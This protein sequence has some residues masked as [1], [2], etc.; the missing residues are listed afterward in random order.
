MLEAVA[1][2]H[3]VDDQLW[4]EAGILGRRCPGQSADVQVE[5]VK[6]VANFLP[7]DERQRLIRGGVSEIEAPTQL[8]VRLDREKAKGAVV[9]PF[10]F[11]GL[12]A[13]ADASA[14][15]IFVR[16]SDGFDLETTLAKR[17]D[18]CL[19]SLSHARPRL[20]KQ[21]NLIS[22]RRPVRHGGAGRDAVWIAFDR[23]H[24]QHFA[25][26]IS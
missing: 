4:R 26:E 13:V 9:N 3:P 11:R 1:P 20:V 24:A 16:L 19:E 14:A 21:V 25:F 10:D 17:G 8:Q 6:V 23:Q 2:P 18:I 15:K 12:I 22:R 7:T 5:A